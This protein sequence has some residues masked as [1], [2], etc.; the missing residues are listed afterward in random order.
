MRAMI[1]RRM[2]TNDGEQ[3]ARDF[4]PERQNAKYLGRNEKI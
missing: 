3:E 1:R 2:R 4:D